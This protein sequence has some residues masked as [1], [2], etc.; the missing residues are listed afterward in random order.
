MQE[1]SYR[2]LRFSAHWL[3]GV[4]DFHL[5][6]LAHIHQIHATF[7]VEAIQQS[8][9]QSFGEHGRLSKPDRLTEA[10]IAWPPW[11]PLGALRADR[12]AIAFPAGLRKT[13]RGDIVLAGVVVGVLAL[14]GSSATIPVSGLA[15]RKL[16]TWRR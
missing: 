5:G 11:L 6:C 8:V 7:G 13:G 9:R 2:G 10:T 3:D 15:W 12:Q 4:F 14:D 16:R 1:R